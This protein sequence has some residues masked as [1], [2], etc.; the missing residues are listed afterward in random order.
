VIITK[1]SQQKSESPP[2]QVKA[3]VMPKIWKARKQLK[4][5]LK[6][7]PEHDINK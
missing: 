3:Q 4:R 7:K 2:L 1:F 6:I 5:L